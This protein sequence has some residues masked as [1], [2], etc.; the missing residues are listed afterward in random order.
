MHE[1][2]DKIESNKQK[3]RKTDNDQ[4][5]TVIQLPTETRIPDKEDDEVEEGKLERKRQRKE[6]GGPRKFLGGVMRDMELA[7]E[8]DWE[9]RR[10]EILAR[11]EKEEV[12]RTRKIE[13]A[14]K[15]QRSWELNRECRK[16]LQE[17]N[18]N[19]VSLEDRI[20][21]QKTKENREHQIGKAQE[22]KRKY[23]EK[24]VIK[25]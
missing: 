7:E 23:K 20:E 21:E 17:L 2:Q 14:E 24:Q 9:K 12:E 1:G 18:N 10:Q 8:V 5:K 11:L 19:W 3:R 25:E 22:K 16:I 6:E 13:K 15:L 4:Y